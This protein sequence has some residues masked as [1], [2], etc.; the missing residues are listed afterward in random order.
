MFLAP[1]N[2]SPS[3]W[4]ATKCDAYAHGWVLAYDGGEWGG[5]L[6]LT[7]DDGSL[8]KRIVSDN[9]RAVVP[10][11]GGILVLSGLAHLADST[12]ENVHI[13]G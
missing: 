6:W 12:T 11:D 3:Q 10:I 8:T 2:R 1:A 9:V 7:N 4:P 5:G 13:L